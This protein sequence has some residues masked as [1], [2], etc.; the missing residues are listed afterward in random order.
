MVIVESAGI[1]DIGKKRKGNEDYLI[2]DDSLN[3]FMVADG[4]GGHQAGEIA[5]RL[6]LETIQNYMQRFK[7][8]EDVE[9]LEDTDDSLSKEANRLLS[10]I[11]L[12]NRGVFQVSNSKDAYYGMGTTVSAVLFTG[13]T[14]ISA[15]IGDSP[16]YLVHNNQIELI[17]VL[18]TVAAEHAAIDPEGAKK[19]NGKFSHVLTQALGVREEI[20][21][22]ICESQCHKDDIVVIGSDGLSDKV[23]PG[24]ICD[25]VN[26]QRCA[27]ACST[28]VDLANS[29]GGDDNI[30]VVI[31]KIKKVY[32]QKKFS[33]VIMSSFSRFTKA[34]K[35]FSLNKN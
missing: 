2:L 35:R 21:P 6:A 16:V 20:K 12:A 5:S 23:S 25:V 26:T 31:L 17:S 7:G 33:D 14:V 15:N 10:S 11:Y 34:F 24:E 32:G 29:R 13:Q 30:T 9:E 3:L 27:K 4:M 19:L 8:N 28:L 18:H 1:T 22:D